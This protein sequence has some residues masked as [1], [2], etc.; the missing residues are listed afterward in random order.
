MADGSAAADKGGRGLQEER[1]ERVGA[2]EE[3]GVNA[4]DMVPEAR[5]TDVEE[6]ENPLG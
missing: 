5:F 4:V 6:K 3:E 2:G 1:V